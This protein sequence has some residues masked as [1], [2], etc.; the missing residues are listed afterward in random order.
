MKIRE[1]ERRAV[2][3]K[4]NSITRR[5]METTI[6]ARQ[7]TVWILWL[8]PTHRIMVSVVRVNRPR[9]VEDQV[10]ILSAC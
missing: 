4:G 2:A 5:A 8:T 9:G 1:R 6:S 7:I 10:S 3:P